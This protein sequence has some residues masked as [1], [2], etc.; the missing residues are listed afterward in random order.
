MTQIKLIVSD[1]DGVLAELKEAHYNALNEAL[2]SIDK[3]YIITPEQ[4]IT[5][6]DGL[7]TYQKLN[8]LHIDRGLSKDSID[9]I[10][11]LKQ[12]LTENAINNCLARN[13][14]L[15]NTFS[16]LK[17][18][19]YIIYVASNAIRKTIVN[20]LKKIGI[21]DLIDRIFSNEDVKNTKPHSEIYLQC[22]LAA[23]VNPDETLI[24]EDSPNGKTAAIKSGAIV[25][26]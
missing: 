3:K 15:I 18:E 26:D 6:F 22:M 17:E 16:K 10:F 12:K 20:G 19:G 13:D 11:E 5:E 4:H 8:K 24:I 9:Q 7:S 14:K 25:C 1:F 23:G 21:Y 2:L